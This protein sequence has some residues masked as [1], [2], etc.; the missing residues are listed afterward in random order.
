MLSL[1]FILDLSIENAFFYTISIVIYENN[2][3]F[4]EFV[5]N[6]NYHL[7]LN[8]NPWPGPGKGSRRTILTPFIRTS[9]YLN[10]INSIVL[11]EESPEDL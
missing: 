10:A 7:L 11:E 4:S 2:G 8:L 1:L 6:T 5:I 9:K 3:Y